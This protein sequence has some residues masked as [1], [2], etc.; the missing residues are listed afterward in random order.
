MLDLVQNVE[1]YTHWYWTRLDCYILTST[2]CYTSKK[3]PRIPN[4]WKLYFDSNSC[5]ISLLPPPLFWDMTSLCRPGL[6]FI[7]I[8]LPLTPEIKDVSQLPAQAS[9]YFLFLPFFFLRQGHTSL[10]WPWTMPPKM[11]L[12]LRSSCSSLPNF[13]TRGKWCHCVWLC[14]GVLLLLFYIYVC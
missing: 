11:A 3:T 14:C 6:K 13:R 1:C 4:R 5:S 7:E 12:N 10:G 9:L 8:C 2:D